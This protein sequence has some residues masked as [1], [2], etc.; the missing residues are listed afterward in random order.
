MNGIS[1]LITRDMIK[2]ISPSI[3]LE[4]NKKAAICK[5]GRKVSPRT[6]PFQYPD[7]RLPA[8][9]TVRKKC[10]LFKPPIL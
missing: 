6:H 1:A 7:L 9:G 5:L 4:Y 3:R 2:M 10:L 8:S